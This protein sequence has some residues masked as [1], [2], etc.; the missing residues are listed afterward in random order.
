MLIGVIPVVPA[1]LLTIIVELLTFGVCR[2]ISM[3][4]MTL[5][6]TERK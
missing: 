1:Q 3:T 2:G 5:R 4:I 6:G